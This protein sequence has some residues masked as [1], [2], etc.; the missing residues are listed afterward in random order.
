[1]VVSRI[2][3][4]TLCDGN[5]LAVTADHL[6]IVKPRDDQDQVFRWVAARIARTAVFTETSKTTSA[7]SLPAPLTRFNAADLVSLYK[8]SVVRVRSEFF[9]ADIVGYW[10]LAEPR[11]YIDSGPSI[12]S[13]LTRVLVRFAEESRELSVELV[14][15][16]EE[17]DLALLRL[18]DPSQNRKPLP[19]VSTGT[20]PAASRLF[21]LGFDVSRPDLDLMIWEVAL[22]SASRDGFWRTTGAGLAP[23]RSGSP[24]IDERGLVVGIVRGS[25]EPAGGSSDAIIVPVSSM[26]PLVR[27]LPR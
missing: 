18:V 10:I 7:I 20:I 21:I 19:V 5:P 23:G 9:R 15:R 16:D 22:I 8:G 4:A 11:I 26:A 2:Y 1:M 14:Q 6:S 3:A 13:G 27:S 24:V 17:S 25:T 12:S